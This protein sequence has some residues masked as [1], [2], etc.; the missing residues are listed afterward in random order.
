MLLIL[1]TLLTGALSSSV[2]VSTPPDHGLVFQGA[3][4]VVSEVSAR[5]LPDLPAAQVL[6][7]RAFTA[8][9]KMPEV[10]HLKTRARLKE[11]LVEAWLDAG[12]PVEEAWVWVEQI[13]NWRRALGA[14]AI[15]V[16]HADAG[17]AAAAEAALGR[18]EQF[19]RALTE[20]SE[21]GW[22]RDRVRARI[23]LAHAKLGDKV[24]AARIQARIDPTE[25]GVLTVH[26]AGVL[27]PDLIEPQAELL[28]RIAREGTSEEARFA[29]EGVT[30]FYGRVHG[31]SELRDRLYER[32]IGSWSQIPLVPRI[33][34]LEGFIGG[35][36]EH[37]ATSLASEKIDRMEALVVGSKVLLEDQV[38]LRARVA[39]LRGLAGEMEAGRAMADQALAKYDELREAINSIWRGRAL[40]PLAAAYQ[41][42][43]KEMIAGDL[44]E[45]A[46][47][48]AQLNP[49]SRPR[50]EDLVKTSIAIAASG[51]TPDASLEQALERVARSLGEPW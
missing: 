29:L 44:F 14:A 35:D 38:A 10:P 40:R 13:S 21:Q 28:F 12:G 18:A 43:G 17:Q 19:E 31:D 33:E 23:G 3:D 39:R 42:L 46:L 48:E 49:N 47:V 26:A 2:A 7:G 24:R 32:A 9:S 4:E 34:I 1:T 15:A 45:R 37:E 50:V 30:R 5:S 41:V 36:L 51:L 6:L 27:D 25:G 8:V 11:D 20:P 22:R 16:H